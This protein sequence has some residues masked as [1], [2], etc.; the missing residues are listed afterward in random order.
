M[1]F[2]GTF[3]LL[4]AALCSAGVVPNPGLVNDQPAPALALAPEAAPE[5]AQL[6]SRV[7]SSDLGSMD[8]E[9]FRRQ[10]WVN[11]LFSFPLLRVNQANRV[12]IQRTI[13]R[14]RDDTFTV[15][16]LS[17]RIIAERVNSDRHIGVI[18]DN[19]SLLSGSIV[20]SNYRDT[21]SSTVARETV[22]VEYGPGVTR[23]CIRLPRLD[24]TWY[25]QISD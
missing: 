3:F 15:A 7:P 22:T 2:L 14:Q 20:L 17:V 6:E 24:G 18:I 11:C 21:R 25:V 23:T 10:K 16:Y 8:M 9:L 1:R 13:T 12:N 5:V 19:S 4:A